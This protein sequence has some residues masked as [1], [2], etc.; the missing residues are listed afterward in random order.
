L[1]KVLGW[2]VY[3]HGGKPRENNE[4][5]SENKENPISSIVIVISLLNP[6]VLELLHAPF[7]FLGEISY[8]LYLLHTL[9]IE[10]CMKELQNYWVE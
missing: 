1:T 8:C 9:I 3:S 6:I 7:Q 10:W 2:S 5:W 4:N